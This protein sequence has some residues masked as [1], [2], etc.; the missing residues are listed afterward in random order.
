MAVINAFAKF[1]VRKRKSMPVTKVPK[2]VREAFNIDT[3][4]KNGIAKLEP[5]TKNCLYDRC[6]LFED[7]N[8][9]NKDEEEKSEF[10]N[11]FMAWLKSINMEFKITIAN[12]YQSIDEFLSSVRETPNES[13]YPEIAEGIDQWIEEKLEDSNP[14]VTTLRYLTVSCRAASMEDARVAFNALDTNIQNAFSLW[15]SRIIPLNAQERL[16]T[17]HSLLCPG[18]KDEIDYIRF[19]AGHNWKNDVLPRSIISQSNYMLLDDVHVSVLFGS[20]Y[21]GS[22]D[23][24]TFIHPFTT[25]EFPAFITMDYAPVPPDEIIDYLTAAGINVEKSISDEEDYRRKKNIISSGPSYAK[26]RKK[27]EVEGL[28]DQVVENDE[29]G[30]FLN[31]L[32]V[33]TAPDEE[34]LSKRVRKYIRVGKTAGIILETANYQQL[35]AL[36]TAL[37]IGGRQVD[38]MRFFLSSSVAA[39]HPFYAQ[40]IIQPGGYFYG[41]NMLTN[42]V[43]MINPKKQM[44]PHI[45]YIGHT[46]SGKSYAMKSMIE[47]ALIGSNDDILVIDPQNEAYDIVS[48]YGGKYFD[49][50]PKSGVYFNGFE[51]YEEVFWGDH[52]LK[53]RFISTQTRYARSLLAAVMKNI[54]FTQEH[55]TIIGRCTR[56]M[57]EMIFAQKR[58]KKQATLILLRD[59]IK[60]ELDEA[61]SEYD[62]N[63]IRPIYNSME[64][65]TEGSCDM[66]SR[67]S[68]IRYDERLVGFGMKN[69]PEDNW[70]AVMLS[71]MHFVS[72]RMEYNQQFRKATHFIVDET[73]VISR[74]GTSA[75]LLMSAVATFRKFGGICTLIMQNIT[76]ALTNES[77]KELYSNCAIKVFFDQGGVDANALSEIQELTRS[78]MAALNNDQPGK[79]ILVCGKKVVPIDM[80]MSKNNPLYKVN[81]TNFYEE[82]SRHIRKESDETQKKNLKEEK[83]EKKISKLQSVKSK[84]PVTE[85]QSNIRKIILQMA[86]Y[87]DVTVNDIKRM[88]TPEDEEYIRETL[89][90]LV[91]SGE[92]VEM[93]D[94]SAG[95]AA[96]RYRKAG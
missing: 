96:I 65:Y 54:V 3:L 45:M 17:I 87:Q 35:R 26:Q 61:E 39:F 10:L 49:L 1:R 40:D 47:Q 16:Y 69:V 91:S 67:P 11:D 72:T 38:Y 92:L 25:T 15:Q 76:A 93:K 80:T 55:A 84:D 34:T 22:V 52:N 20:R 4:Y 7:V 50:T 33:L 14:N 32:L 59:E 90:Q 23:P 18:K 79:G 78:E 74:K 66:L 5:G 68:N 53:E 73:Q 82:D 43:V 85:K 89:S 63:I 9:I 2:K 48:R 62:K 88:F 41:R 58:L 42:R 21:Q 28:Q 6:Y 29:T 94:A 46:G 51:V 13:L 12:E 64:E 27:D 60:K 57:Y 19:A 8:Y 75:E 31:F 44:N 81:S 36:N 71:I 24:D 77:L 56:R 30:F 86:G 83:K 95:L 37:P 70:E